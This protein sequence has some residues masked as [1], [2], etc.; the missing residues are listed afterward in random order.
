[1]NR[2]DNEESTAAPGIPVGDPALRGT[3]SGRAVLAAAKS[4]ASVLSRASDT[5]AAC[6]FLLVLDFAHRR[7]AHLKDNGHAATGTCHPVIQSGSVPR[8]T[9]GGRCACR[10][11]RVQSRGASV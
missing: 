5:A 9:C 2:T 11:G 7:F 4:F 8:R 3:V 10:G 1:M 6:G